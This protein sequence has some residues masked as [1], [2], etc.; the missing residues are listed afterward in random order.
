MHEIQQIAARVRA[1]ER[2]DR[3][4]A[5]ALYQG[6][7]TALLGDLADGI[8]AR[9]HPERV[10]TYIID[11]NV[12][13]TNICVA[14]CNFCAFYRPVGSG[15][16]YV[17]G[18]DEIFRKIDETIEL[19]G[20]QL[21][22]QGRAQSRSA[23]GVVRGSLPLGEGAVSRVQAARAVAA[24]GDPPHADVAPDDR[25]GDRAA[26]R[27]RARQH[28]GRRRRDPRGPRPQDPQ[29][30]QQGHGRRVARRH[31]PRAPRRA[32]HHGDD[33]VRACGDAGG[34]ARAHVPPA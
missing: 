19:G 20:G 15:E 9:K 23:A 27:G 22:L 24:G 13:Y 5:L 30:L 12:N 25:A 28:P 10:V 17:L 29:L 33:D 11:R 26:G 4:E 16:G 1:G 14:R 3:R 2:I 8:R 18:F 32:A 7:P 6:A 34:A 21:L 31:A